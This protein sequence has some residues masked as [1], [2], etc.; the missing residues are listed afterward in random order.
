VE[1]GRVQRLHRQRVRWITSLIS[2]GA[3]FNDA[4]VEVTRAGLSSLRRVT[5]VGGDKPTVIVVGAINVDLVV[6]TLRL[7]GPGDGRRRGLRR[8]E[9]ARVPT[10]VA[11]A[12][13]GDGA[14]DRRV[15]ADDTSAAALAELAAEGIDTSGVAVLADQSTGVALI[16][17]DQ[18]GENQIAVGSGANAAV[19]ADH[20]RRSLSEA[21]STGLR[22]SRRAPR[23]APSW[24]P[25]RR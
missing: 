6:I 21:I 11:A 5:G 13:A 24:R 16:V 20:V 15:G 25:P 23:R 18:H 10:A 12:R 1:L 22:G 19:T 2:R 8:T 4:R 3:S 9:A 17:V 7:P 14:A